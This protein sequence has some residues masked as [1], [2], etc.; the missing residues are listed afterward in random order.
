MEDWETASLTRLK[1]MYKQRLDEIEY[2]KIII[3][4][5]EELFV[6]KNWSRF[7][8]SRK[9]EEETFFKKELGFYV[10]IDGVPT[11]IYSQ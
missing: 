10:G 2:M 8:M 5:Y 7:R 9:R 1:I 3:R 6:E 4:D 11:Y